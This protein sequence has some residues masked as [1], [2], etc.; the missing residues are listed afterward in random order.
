MKKGKKA[1]LIV[2]IIIAVLVGTMAIA[3]FKG[4]RYVRLMSVNPID[5]SKI[6]DGVHAGS[7]K[8]GRFAYFVEVAVKDGRIQAVK[9]AD[10]KQAKSAII[11]Q[12][13]ARLVQEQSVQVDTVSGA[14]LTTKAVTKAVENALKTA[15]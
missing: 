14:S 1:L 12:I 6:A 15:R 11:E 9:A 8:K 13:L 2:G 4:L 3:T 7:F 10:T 5:L